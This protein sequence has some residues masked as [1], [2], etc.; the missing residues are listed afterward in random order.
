[1]L[2]SPPVAEFKLDTTIVDQDLSA[3]FPEPVEHLEELL[4]VCRP[5]SWH[6]AL[7]VAHP[8]ASSYR[9]YP[10]DWFSPEAGF[11]LG[12]QWVTR[13]ARDPSTGK[14]CGDGIRIGPFVLDHTLRRP[15]R[16]L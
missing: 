1:M 12:Y 7:L 5:V 15:E 3:S 4:L 13:V 6:L 11:D 2:G 16:K 10:Q 8:A 14:V 9:L